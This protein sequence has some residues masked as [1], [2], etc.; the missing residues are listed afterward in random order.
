MTQAQPAKTM[1]FRTQYDSDYRSEIFWTDPGEDEG[2]VQH[3]MTAETDVNN[4]MAKYQATGDISHLGEI[5]G[6]YGDFSDVYDYK[7]GLDRIN[8]ANEI[9]MELPSLI[10]D[11]FNNDPAKFVEFATNADNQEE[12]RKMGLAPPAPLPPEP[13]L[14]KVVEEPDDA[15]AASKRPAGKAGDQ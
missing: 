9:F 7:S 15:K 4:I 6:S 8:A 1:R 11:R 5:A 2:L 13:Q 3:H 10:R 12:L 14:V